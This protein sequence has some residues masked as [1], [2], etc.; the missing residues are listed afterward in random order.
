MSIYLKKK[1]G[2]VSF[3]LQLEGPFQASKNTGLLDSFLTGCLLLFLSQYVIS[4]PFF[5]SSPLSF[6]SHVL[7]SV[8]CNDWQLQPEATKKGL[9]LYLLVL[10]SACAITVCF[11]FSSLV[12]G[13]GGEEGRRTWILNPQNC[14]YMLCS[15]VRC[16]T[17]LPT[18]PSPFGSFQILKFPRRSSSLQPRSGNVCHLVGFGRVTSITE[19]P[20]WL[21][22]SQITLWNGGSG[23]C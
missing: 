2:G 22:Y 16:T 7:C 1:S 23:S 18:A 20:R 9:L 17:D 13:R 3:S 19:P 6:T 21:N 12:V 8:Q 11:L 10:H 5:S 4:P 15:L 14:E